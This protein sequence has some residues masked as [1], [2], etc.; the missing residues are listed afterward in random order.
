MRFCHRDLRKSAENGPDH[1]R[2]GLSICGRC[3]NWRAVVKKQQSAD[4]PA[5]WQEASE[6]DRNLVATGEGR[7]AEDVKAESESCPGT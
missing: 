7:Q 5:T 3:G 4:Q 6:A 1:D 2:S